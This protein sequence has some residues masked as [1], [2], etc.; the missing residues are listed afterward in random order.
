MCRILNESVA[1][2]FGTIKRTTTYPYSVTRQQIQ[3]LQGWHFKWNETCPHHTFMVLIQCT[4]FGDLL[5]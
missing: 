5:Y 2:L 1:T 3:N 4:M